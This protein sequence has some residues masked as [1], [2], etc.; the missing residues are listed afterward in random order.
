M[1]DSRRYDSVARDYDAWASHYDQDDNA[2][3]DLD[4]QAVREMI[5]PAALAGDVLEIGCGTG[6]N[7]LYLAER[8][9]SVTA[10]DFSDGMLKRAKERVTSPRVKFVRHDIREVWQ[11]ADRSFDFV[12]VNLVLEHIEHIAFVFQ[13]SSRVL[14]PGGQM[15]V[16]ELHPF[17]QLLGRQARF[18][19]EESGEEVDVPAHLHEISDFI[20]DARS[21]GLGLL[22]IEERRID[23]EPRT[24]VPRLLALLFQ[25]GA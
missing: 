24:V 20:T 22:K 8:A 17:R 6:K 2:T 25:K 18:Q 1:S 9:K 11:L 14:R 23:A 19:D 15:F 12:T 13:E 16:A 5:P 4:A 21:V 3:R 10:I 7:T